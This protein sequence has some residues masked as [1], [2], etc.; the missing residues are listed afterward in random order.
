MDDKAPKFLSAAQVRR[1]YGDVSDMTL[2]RWLL[3]ERMA[4]PRPLYFQRMR[5]WSEEDLEAWER[6]RAQRPRPSPPAPPRSRTTE[7]A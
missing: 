1:R 6:T 3:D 2:N 4:F 7:A 5:Y